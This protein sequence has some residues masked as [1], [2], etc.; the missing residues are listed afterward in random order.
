V[1][2]SDDNLA[3]LRAALIDFH[4]ATHSNGR[5]RS[6]S[7][8]A[9]MIVEAAQHLAPPE[10]DG[11]DTWP[12]NDDDRLPL[13]ANDD[14]YKPFAEA[15]RRFAA[16]TQVPSIERL[17][18][19]C[20]LLVAKSFLT[21]ADLQQSG[22]PSLLHTFREFFEGG[23]QEPVAPLV[24]GRFA[25]ERRHASGRI[26]LS[27]MTTG[28]S[29]TGPAAIEEYVYNLRQAPQSTKREALVRLLS[30]TGGSEQRLTGWLFQ[31]TRQTCLVLQDTLRGEST[32]HLLVDFKPT[33]EPGAARLFLL[34]S[35]D[36]GFTQPTYEKGCMK[37]ITDATYLDGALTRIKD[38][39]WYYRQ[40]AADG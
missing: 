11:D 8:I 3:R 35:H 4:A 13:S 37:L 32:I 23:G 38:R 6:W 19:L 26:E 9:A 15:L 30:R 16:G 25:A 17:D 2:Y 28:D 10:E 31:T 21:R 33:H 12:Q 39:L 5:R 20:E 36:F 1:E 7:V 14:P 40:V 18:A 27:F 24:T 29:Q 34:K 22:T